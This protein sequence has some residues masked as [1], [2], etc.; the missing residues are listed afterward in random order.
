MMDLTSINKKS[1]VNNTVK[2]D[3]GSVAVIS[4]RS[5]IVSGLTT[6]VRLNG[7]F[8]AKVFHKPF[9][10]MKDDK[11]ISDCDYIII[12]IVDNQ[13]V[14]F[15]ADKI[16][17]TFPVTAKKLFVG[18]IDSLSF[19]D[20]MKRAGMAYL[21]IESQIMS[22]GASL[23]N[24]AAQS[25]SAQTQK[26]SI[27]GSKGGC[28]TSTIAYHLYQSIGKLSTLPILLV[29]GHTGTADMDLIS[30]VVIRRDGTITQAAAH[31]G[32]KI[33][34]EEEQWKFNDAAYNAYNI[35]VF[36]HSVITQ[37]RDKL[38]HIIA[39]SDYIF[40]VVTRELSS[41]RNGRTILDELDRGTGGSS[42]QSE[43]TKKSKHIIILNENH[44]DKPG[45]LSNEDIENY[46]GKQLDIVILYSK[47][48]K[49]EKVYAPLH[50]FSSQ[51][52][53][54]EVANSKKAKKSSLF[55]LVKSIKK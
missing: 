40:I 11:E 2:L 44:P 54:R 39:G 30:D 38:V 5:H 12:D 23:A 29:Q 46:L 32:L 19:Y 51:M 25:E 33:E 9:E 34:S 41:V 20:E 14:Q 22:L 4:H 49:G 31:M 43:L 26:I 37:T 8:E 10:E 7:G 47:G 50:D 36:D 18:D 55:D 27:L 21:H 28:G 15:L 35:V 17:N 48:I 16:K 3:A 53:G 42:N 24:L 6:Q 52:L 45:E 13:N 1:T